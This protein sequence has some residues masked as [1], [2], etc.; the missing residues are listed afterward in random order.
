MIELDTNNSIPSV[1]LAKDGEKILIFMI[2]ISNIETDKWNFS[3][4]K[5][6][7]MTKCSHSILSLLF[8]MI[9]WNCNFFFK[10]IQVTAF[11]ISLRNADE[12][13]V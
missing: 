2:M 7:G 11:Q 12:R 3:R 8:M 13:L 6:E 9:N 10:L 5:F 1:Y 4:T